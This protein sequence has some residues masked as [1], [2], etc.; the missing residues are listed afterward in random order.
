MAIKI[1]LEKAYD[2]LELSFI[3]DTLR[4]VNLPESLT[5]L[6]M[7]CAS[8]VSTSILFNEGCLEEFC[9]TR[10]IRQGGP[11]SHYL[12]ILCVDCL[13]QLIE[14]KCEA[15]IWTLV[16]ASR[17]GPAF[18]L[19]FFTDNLVLFAEAAHVNCLAI[20]E[21]LD[22][23]CNKL[24]QTV[25]GSSKVFFSPNVDRDTRE[26]LGDILGFRTTCAIEKFL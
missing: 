7:S 12:F 22:S 15:K 3:R 5:D 26:A 18:S 1:D 9:P 6:I 19:L 10:G 13:G 14:E 2:K 21:V 17:G 16:K 20:T 24:G 23:F 11:F 4:R 8:T 25:S